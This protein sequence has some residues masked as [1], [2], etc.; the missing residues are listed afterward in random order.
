MP[1]MASFLQIG[2]LPRVIETSI[3]NG[4]PK[5]VRGATTTMVLSWPHLA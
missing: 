3:R 4:F 1:K 5:M 2:L